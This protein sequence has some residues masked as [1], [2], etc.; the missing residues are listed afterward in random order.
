MMPRRRAY[1]LVECLVAITLLGS[2]LGT[3]TLTLTAM[4]R[5]DR[6][7]RDALDQE[8]ALELFTARFRSDVH[9]A[10]SA[11]I[12]KPTEANAPAC[13][14]LLRSSE[15][16]TIQYSLRPRDVERVVRRGATIV[17]R[18]T[19]GLAAA[20]ATWQIREDPKP[21]MVSVS[22]DPQATPGRDP[23]R[24]PEAVRIDAVVHLVRAPP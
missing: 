2:L 13:E 6:R 15:D 11:S 7:L 22:L 12:S 20:T 19:Y 24:L 14:L 10:H 23:Y 1:S 3:V 8:R 9:E 21:A 4:Y 18:E 17:H 16:Q 5:S